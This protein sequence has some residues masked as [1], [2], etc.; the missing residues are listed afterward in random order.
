QGSRSNRWCHRSD[1]RF[2]D[3]NRR[4]HGRNNRRRRHGRWWWSWWSD[5]LLSRRGLCWLWLRRLSLNFRFGRCYLC[6]ERA[7]FGSFN[8]GLSYW[9]CLSYLDL[10]FDYGRCLGWFLFDFLAREV[11]LNVL[12]A[13]SVNIAGSRDSFDPLS[14][15]VGND[16]QR[17]DLELF[18]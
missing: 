13:L 2:L 18:R 1:D 6:R 8:R 9:L 12:N 16:L 11:V 10:G 3:H 4:R 17:F 5:G 7:G 14:L 15:K